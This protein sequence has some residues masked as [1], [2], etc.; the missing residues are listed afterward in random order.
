[1]QSTLLQDPLLTGAISTNSVSKKLLSWFDKHGRKNLPWQQNKTPY[2]VWISEIML[3]QTQVATVIPYYQKFMASFP[4]IITLAN[5]DEDEVLN[6][7]S[8]LGYYARARNL[9]KTAKIVRDEYN[10]DFP[11]EFDSVLALPGIGRSTAGAVLSLSLGQHHVI[12]DGNVKRVMARL[13]CIEGWYGHL[14]VQNELWGVASLHTPEKRVADYNQAIMDLGATLCVR[15]KNVQCNSCP[16]HEDCS[17][18][19]TNQVSTF[20]YSKPKKTIPVRKTQMLMICNENNDVYIEK[21][22]PAGIWGGLWSLPQLDEDENLE[23]WCKTNISHEISDLSSWDEVR[24]T[25]SHF[26]LDITPVLV[27]VKNHKNIVMEEKATVWYKLGQNQDRGYATPVMKLL[28]KL[29]IELA[30]N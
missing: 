4:D 21:R 26:H 30:L 6:H 9:H 17:A 1:M 28:Q 10:G 13:H 14:K 27:K 7:W 18:Y 20:P 15:G 8:G 29:E 5:A 11:A 3:Q 23:Q 22:P 2:R 12:L 19:Q 24:H 16:L 25:F